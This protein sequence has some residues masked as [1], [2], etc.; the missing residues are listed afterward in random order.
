MNLES[1]QFPDSFLFHSFSSREN[2]NPEPAQQ[3]SKSDLYYIAHENG[4]SIP[5]ERLPLLFVDQA[6][7]L[8]L[9]T[10][11]QM[12]KGLDKKAPVSIVSVFGAARTGKSFLLNCLAGRAGLFPCNNQHLPC[13]KGCDISGYASKLQ[14]IA[15]HANVSMPDSMKSAR[16]AWV[17]C[18]GSGD[19][20]VS[21]D[22][23]LAM[24]L[25]VSSKV[26]IFN[27][28][29]A[30]TASSML[31]QLSVLARTAEG[32]EGHGHSHN[33]I[34]GNT[35][36]S[37]KSNHHPKIFGHLH[38]VLRDYCYDT[39][40]EEIM[41]KI[42][43]EEP[44]P[45]KIMLPRLAKKSEQDS[46]GGIKRLV[47]GGGH[48][49]SRS[50]KERNDIRQMLKSSFASIN[51]WLLTQPGEPNQLKIHRELP[52]EKINPEFVG[53]VHELLHEI[54][55]QLAETQIMTGPNTATVLTRAMQQIN[56]DGKVRILSTMEGMERE[57][58]KVTGNF[59][60]HRD[61]ET[62]SEQIRQRFPVSQVELQKVC[63]D[64]LRETLLQYDAKLED[65][66]AG[67]GDRSTQRKDIEDAFHVRLKELE[68]ENFDATVK[69]VK[70][71]VEREM[72]MFRRQFIA[73]VE[74]GGQEAGD[75]TI[76]HKKEA[77][78]PSTVKP[79][80]SEQKT[81]ELEH[82]PAPVTPRKGEQWKSSRS[83]SDVKVSK[84]IKISLT[85]AELDGLFEQIKAS[86][87]A[88]LEVTLE[89]LPG[90]LELDVTKDALWAEEEKL[91]ELLSVYTMKR[92]LQDQTDSE[93]VWATAQANVFLDKMDAGMSTAPLSQKPLDAAGHKLMSLLKGRKH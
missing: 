22:T 65:V 46:H 5:A 93:M 45:A 2:S 72:G 16:V 51:L 75:T 61:L 89:E 34:S 88:R 62:F 43:G 32:I 67:E 26:V 64:Y 85:Q 33:S 35:S 91:L 23:K 90:A 14:S 59:L 80:D 40:K 7:S 20:D 83:E 30:P 48:D 13:T 82:V 87:M 8:Q 6:G 79:P 68:T 69:W 92:H 28:K 76:V 53:Q 38:L 37:S 42:L 27:H 39:S 24:P 86:T 18:E 73:A 56:K 74:A 52:E 10:G 17:D 25:L 84:S 47:L 19:Q 3:R 58:I 15:D 49:P 60:S 70:H 63:H 36:S 78:R 21:Y 29:G 12:L 71:V 50:A 57:H 31:D 55:Q 4:S 44:I 11:L 77:R 1:M 9:G 66:I 54:A 41:E 81:L